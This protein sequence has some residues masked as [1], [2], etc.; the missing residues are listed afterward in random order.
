MF[1]VNATASFVIG[2]VTINRMTN[3]TGG[4][5]GPATKRFVDAKI[6]LSPLTATNNVGQAHTIIATVSQDDGLPSGAPGDGATGFGAAP[7]GTL[8]TFSLL[9]NTATPPIAFVGNVNTCTT[10][11]GCS[12]QINSNVAGSVDI[13]ATTTFSVGG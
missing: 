7:N 12:V 2:S 4:N 11:V 1:T 13:H 9:N 10:T 6:V 5:S 8:V 3:G